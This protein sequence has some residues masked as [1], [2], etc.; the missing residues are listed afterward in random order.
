MLTTVKLT[1]T[2][3][4]GWWCSARDLTVKTVTVDQQNTKVAIC[5]KK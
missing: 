5:K 3:A 4:V 1:Q 2:S